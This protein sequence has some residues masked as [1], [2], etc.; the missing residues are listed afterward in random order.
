M[1]ADDGLKHPWIASFAASS[2]FKN[3]HGSISS[4]WLKS[5]SRLNSAKSN[6]S[7]RSSK[8]SRSGKSVLSKHRQ[9]ASSH[10]SK[11]TGR[12]DKTIIAAAAAGAIATL[13]GSSRL[14]STNLKLTRQL[15]D[16][17]Q[18]VSKDESRDSPAS[19]E[20][21]ASISGNSN[22]TVQHSALEMHRVNHK[23]QQTGP[24]PVPSSSH[25]RLNK[26][27]HGNEPG[28]H[29]PMS[30]GEA[31]RYPFLPPLTS[32]HSKFLNNNS[33]ETV[34]FPGLQT[35]TLC[36]L[37]ER[38]ETMDI[39][40][41]STHPTLLT[42]TF[43]PSRDVTQRNNFFDK[44]PLDDATSTMLLKP[45]PMD[46]DCSSCDGTASC[47]SSVISTSP[48][49]STIFRPRKSPSTK[50]NKVSNSF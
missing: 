33:K 16:K 25:M 43:D 14:N 19:V 38:E 5:S 2:S 48:G 1:T 32:S 13:P 10:H 34:Q 41:N 31:E 27:M 45:L 21:N 36:K 35:S 30:E 29:S 4:N 6:R 3:L 40:L 47:N 39:H 50:R 12:P 28:G 20:S 46:I 49:K 26:L 7:K 44:S 22:V 23:I 8:S 24:I 15:L 42:S 18:S 17:L 9:S 11:V 37:A